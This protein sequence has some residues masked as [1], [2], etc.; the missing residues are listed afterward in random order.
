MRA[1]RI[2]SLFFFSFIIALLDFAV[3]KLMEGAP[4]YAVGVSLFVT[5]IVFVFMGAKLGCFGMSLAHGAFRA[6]L[7]LFFVPYPLGTLLGVAVGALLGEAITAM[8]KKKRGFITNTLAYLFFYIAY[9]LGSLVSFENGFSIVMGEPFYWTM[10]MVAAGA[11][12]AFIA[13]RLLLYPKL[14]RAGIEK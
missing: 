12:L 2:F 7:M 8:S 3:I 11:V 14:R 13:A 6:L 1:N 5:N 9:A 4:T 10:G